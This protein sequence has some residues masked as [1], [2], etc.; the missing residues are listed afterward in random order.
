MMTDPKQALLARAASIQSKISATVLWKYTDEDGKDFY[1]SE[2]KVGTLKSPH[3]GKSF[4]AKPERSSL[5]DVGKELKE[6]EAKVKGAL[7][8]YTD[9]DGATFYLPERVTGTL[10]SPYTGRS[11]TPK[12]EKMNF[13]EINKAEKTAA[14]STILWKYVGD[15]G[16]TFYL[17]E[18]KIG[19]MRDPFSGST[20]PGHPVRV[21]LTQ[22]AKELRAEGNRTNVI[23]EYT[24]GDG[25]KFYMALRRKGSMKSPYSG[26]SFIADPARLALGKVGEPS[27]PAYDPREAEFQELQ[28][29]LSSHGYDPQDALI[30]QAEG[31]G[32]M[33]LAE[34]LKEPDGLER[35]HALV[36][37]ASTEVTAAL[38]AAEK[39]V[40]DAFFEKKEA[41]GGMLITDGKTLE[42]AGLG[43]KDFAEWKGGKIVV[44]PDRPMVKNDEEILR[45]MK[46]SIPVNTL[47]PHPFFGK[48]ATVAEEFIASGDEHPAIVAIGNAFNEVLAALGEA[49][50]SA[51]HLKEA[52]ED[53]TKYP[54]LLLA[55]LQPKIRR[56][57]EVAAVI[58]KQM[59]DRLA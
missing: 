58:S 22:V 54:A 28:E 44:H 10:K 8:K 12:G 46:K 39:K 42:K 4:T 50:S 16:V 40:V 51:F 52:G 13:G 34:R 45:Y 29:L 11:F 19:M 35:T 23:W 9:G 27:E 20:F 3:T 57:A 7:W 53:S 56:L 36:K 26:K 55:G 30:L 18:K 59:E 33:E 14:A 37:L 15:D 48:S 25:Q 31:M 49:Q 43:G 21:N 41:E 1:L 47:A 24:D 5:S 38:T 6:D 2:K 32:P 17:P